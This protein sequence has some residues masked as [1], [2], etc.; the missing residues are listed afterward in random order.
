M[1]KTLLVLAA[2][3]LVLGMSGMAMAATASGTM[4]T[5]ATL[6]DACTVSAAT[7]TFPGFAALASTAAQTTDTDGSLLVACTT[8][9]SPKIWSDTARTLTGSGGTIAF[10]LSQTAG[11][12]ADNLPI[13]ALASE[14][15]ASYTADGTPIAV[16]LYGRILAANFG[17]KA[18]GAYSANITV[19]VEY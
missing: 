16:P 2:F 14:A 7:M 9:T 5:E 12:A 13:T 17:G 4:T 18:A 6:Q 10:N 3:G 15:I 1:K 19:K 11:A 8:G